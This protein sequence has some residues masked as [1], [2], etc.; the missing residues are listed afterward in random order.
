MKEFP[1]IRRFQVVQE[2]LDQIRLNLV[3]PE[4]AE[5]DRHRLLNAIRET[6]G[7][8]VQLNLQLVPDIPLTG[9]GKLKVVVRNN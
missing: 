7:T 4:L 6:T 9:A 1:A 3:A 8:A 5:G 2:S